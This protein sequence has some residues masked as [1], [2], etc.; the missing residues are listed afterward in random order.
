M[1]LRTSSAFLARGVLVGLC[2]LLPAQSEVSVVALRPDASAGESFERAALLPLPTG[3]V[4][5]R[6]WLREQLRLQRDGFHGQLPEISRFLE[7]DG[8]AWLTPDGEGS[9]GWEEPVYWLKGFGAC[10]YILRDERMLKEARFWIEA[11]LNSQK[12]DGWFGPDGQRGGVATGLKG[13]EDLWPNMI[14]LFCL[15]DWYEFSRDQ[16]VLDLMRRYFDYLKTVPDE[17]F[18][19]GYWPK[20]RGGDLLFSVLWLHFQTGDASLLELARK[21][22]RNTARWDEGVINWHNVNMA[23]GFGY[24]ATFWMVSGDAA[25]LAQ[26]ERNFLEMRQAYGQVPG[27]MFGG[28]ENC[29]PGFTGPRQAVE[30]CGMVEM[31]LSCETLAWITGDPVWADRCEDVAFNQLPAATTADLRAL[32]YLTAPNHVVSDAVPKNPGIQNGGPMYLMDPRDHRCCQHDFGHGW[33]Y[34][35]KH[36]WMGGHDGSLTLMF[37]LASRVE[38]EVGKDRRR[39]GFEVESRYPFDEQI[40]IRVAVEGEPLEFPLHVR[41]P[42]WCD[43]PQV[44]VCGDDHTLD[45]GGRPAGG[46]FLSISRTWADGDDVR[47]GLPMDV[48]L[49]HWTG[50]HGTVSVDRGPLTYSLFVGVEQTSEPHAEIEG[51]D[52]W[53]A[54]SLW[55]ATPWNYGLDL[56][57]EDPVAGIEVVRRQWPVDDRPWFLANAPLELRAPARRIPEWQ[58]DHRNLVDE[59][60]ESPVRTEEPL[61]TIRLVPMGAARLRISAFPVIGHGEDAETWELPARP[62]YRAS[63]S[64]TWW[65]DTADA[66]A[67]G[68]VPESS[69]DGSIPRHTFWSHKGTSEWLVA[70]FDAPRT[71]DRAAVYWFDDSPSGGGCR[72]P[73]AWKLR[74]RDASGAWQ[75]VS[76]DA[77][78]GIAADHFNEVRFAAVTTTALRLE[79]ELRDG[80]SGGVLEWQIGDE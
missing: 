4:E 40:T 34:L 12:A 5:P 61:E 37:P 29:R 35:A 66:V 60:G 25:H 36:L 16:R 68:I 78:L 31:M 32:R 41:V 38:T 30:T 76:T 28:D 74:Y 8:N 15:Q 64:H 23:Q 79:V 27:G 62:L 17:R 50:N 10:A 58:L 57:G 24:P 52:S 56:D 42:G 19:N 21:V 11:I 70:E 18:L 13:R 51:E 75:D 59:V 45:L 33:P 7:K 26:P 47:I 67:D 72:L 14:A 2:A 1:D 48:R 22:H 53:P 49:R 80:F 63:A 55:P 43:T 39:I 73:A 9:H 54:R 71:L 69:S 77:G 46:R 3:M 6:G 20:M 44:I 65:S